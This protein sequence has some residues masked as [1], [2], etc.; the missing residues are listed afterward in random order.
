MFS[1]LETT[2]KLTIIVRNK[3]F[4]DYLQFLHGTEQSSSWLKFFN[5]YKCFGA[6]E[7]EKEGSRLGSSI[8]K[9]ISTFIYEQ[10]A[11][12]VSLGREM[13][14]SISIPAQFVN[15]CFKELYAMS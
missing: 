14:H 13:T 4:A 7:H 8:H 10:T 12:L 11:S 1:K 15:G 6:P 2:K 9:T 3:E 5:G